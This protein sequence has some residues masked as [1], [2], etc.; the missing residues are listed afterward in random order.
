MHLVDVN[1]PDRRVSLVVVNHLH[2]RLV[3]TGVVVRALPLPVEAHLL[4]GQGLRVR[5]HAV[6]RQQRQCPNGLVTS[7]RRAPVFAA[8]A[9]DQC[10]DDLIEDALI[11]RRSAPNLLGVARLVHSVPR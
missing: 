3:N 8:R 4:C 9:P 6:V 5:D 10:V 11:D 2:R 7:N 1:Y